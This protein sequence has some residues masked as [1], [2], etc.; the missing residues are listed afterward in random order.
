[1]T[2]DEI[3]DGLA[4]AQK[5]EIASPE[6]A[7]ACLAEHIKSYMPH[8]NLEIIRK[9]FEYAQSKHGAQQRKSGIPYI[10]HHSRR[11]QGRSGVD[12]GRTP[13]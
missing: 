8:K 9:A 7:Y 12:C 3:I 5:G 10:C 1:M 6:E 11:T 2:P 13:S 4:S